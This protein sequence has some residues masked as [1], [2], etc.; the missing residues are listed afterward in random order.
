MKLESIFLSVSLLVM[1]EIVQACTCIGI[2][3]SIETYNDADG[4]LIGEVIGLK[5]QNRFKRMRVKVLTAYKGTNK[6]YIDIDTELTSC[7]LTG[8]KVGDTWLFHF[9]IRDHRNTTNRCMGNSSSSEAQFASD[10]ALLNQFSSADTITLDSH[11]A[12]G[13]I[14][15]GIPMGYWRYYS[16]SLSDTILISEGNYAHGKRHGLWKSYSPNGSHYSIERYHQGKLLETST[17]NSDSVLIHARETWNKSGQ[18][19]VDRQY[20][21]DGTPYKFFIATLFGLRTKYE[22]YYPNGNLKESGHFDRD[23]NYSGKW[24]YYDTTGKMLKKERPK[25]DD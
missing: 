16:H 13:M 5:E 12:I 10:T 21:P 22:E 14:S 2:S 6:N 20:Y 17:L 11:R 8:P 23:G 3:L 7:M 25:Y 19:K 4:F 24:S 18:Q 9:S 15:S 1:P